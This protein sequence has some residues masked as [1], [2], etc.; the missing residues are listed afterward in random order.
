MGI[1]TKFSVAKCCCCGEC[2]GESGCCKCACKT[3]CFVW[4]DGYKTFSAE[5][6]TVGGR[7]DA[8][9]NTTTGPVSVAVFITTD[10]YGNCVAITYEGSEEKVRYRIPEDM[11]CSAIA[12][13]IST[14]KGTVTFE[15]AVKARTSCTN[16]DCLCQCLC[17]TVYENDGPAGGSNSLNIWFGKACYGYGQFAGS[18]KNIDLVSPDGSVIIA[19]QKT[20]DPYDNQDDCE[21]KVTFNGEDS[22]VI[23][24]NQ[25]L[26]ER[27]NFQMAVPIY[28]QYGNEKYTVLFKCASCEEE[29]EI[30]PNCFCIDPYTG[31]AIFIPNTLTVSFR[32]T[33]EISSDP[34]ST[35]VHEDSF[36]IYWRG[37]NRTQQS[38]AWYSQ[39]YDD[40]DFV[41]GIVGTYDY[42]GSGQADCP[43]RV[44]ANP[45]LCALNPFTLLVDEGGL[46]AGATGVP[47]VIYCDPFDVSYALPFPGDYVTITG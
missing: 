45:L 38:N 10:E 37:K 12:G 27:K 25:T 36:P 21:M 20:S 9:V 43:L 14:S 23:A 30:I 31:E 39:G 41:N 33:I 15:C 18:L 6:D 7:Y 16:C 3:L 4:T 34:P 42:D 13:S 47:D 29:C 46:M 11:S 8:V 26:C 22:E 40:Y 1:L 5:A 17:V 35:C 32:K 44:V 2:D 19:F 24:L 28:D